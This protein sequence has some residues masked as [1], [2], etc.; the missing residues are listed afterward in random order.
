MEALPAIREL[1]RIAQPLLVKEPDT[2]LFPVHFTFR[3]VLERLD[4]S[5]GSLE[6][7]LGNDPLRHYHATGLI[8]RN[9]LSDAL[10]TGYI[11]KSSAVVKEQTEDLDE[12]DSDHA[13]KSSTALEER[14]HEKL[15]ALY[16]DDLQRMD[17]FVELFNETGVLSDEEVHQYRVKH[18]MPNSM[19]KLIRDYAEEFGT[20]SFPSSTAMIKGLLKSDKKDPWVRELQLAFDIWTYFSKYEHLGWHA[21]D[22]TRDMDKSKVHSRLKSV[23]RLA[24]LL[25]SSCHEMLEQKEALKE[26]L[27][28]YKALLPFSSDTLVPN[29]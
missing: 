14:L 19:Y 3:L 24:A 29:D 16:H 18:A 5:L 17:K 23:T 6:L 21:Y 25:Q 11:I 2:V 8:C 7:L 13:A 9:I 15:Y 1:R 28:V 20:R 4:S 10:T 27:A 22:L 26:S 12:S